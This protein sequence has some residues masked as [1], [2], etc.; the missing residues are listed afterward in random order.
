MIPSRQTIHSCRSGALAPRTRAREPAGGGLED[1]SRPCCTD[2]QDTRC[3]ETHAG[4]RTPTRMRR[5]RIHRSGLEVSGF[6]H[7]LTS[8]HVGRLARLTTGNVHVLGKPLLMLAVMIPKMP[9]KLVGYVIANADA[10]TVR[11]DC[12][13]RSCGAFVGREPGTAA[14]YYAVRL[15]VEMPRCRARV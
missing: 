5:R 9:E 4:A 13:Q 3:V 1:S 8:L 14:N 7:R 10:Q 11:R 12:A 15:R 6:V 2:T